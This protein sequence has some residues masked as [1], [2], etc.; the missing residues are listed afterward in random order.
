M[1]QVAKVHTQTSFIKVTKRS[2]EDELYFGEPFGIFWSNINLQVTSI[3]R[4]KRYFKDKQ[5]FITKLCANIGL[6]WEKYMFFPENF[7]K[8]V[9]SEH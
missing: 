6:H 1:K 3:E 9:V 2:W 8:H 7:D 5:R 4:E